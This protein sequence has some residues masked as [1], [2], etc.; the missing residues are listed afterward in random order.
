MLSR[1]FLIFIAIVAFS[2]SPADAGEIHSCKTLKKS[3]QCTVALPEGSVGDIVEI[4]N[5]Y[6]YIVGFGKI[7]QRRGRYS[8]IV[9][10]K[11]IH[12]IK[13]G[14]SVV[15]KK[16]DSNDHWSATTAPF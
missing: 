5:N 7:T 1:L 4:K 10:V 12:D 8:V 2:A 6:S 3:T 9:V 13:S 15:V 14:Y 16:T 11:K